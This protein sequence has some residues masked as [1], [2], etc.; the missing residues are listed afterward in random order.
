MAQERLYNLLPRVYRREDLRKGQPLRALMAVLEN[1]YDTLEQDIRNL[2]DNWFIETCAEWCIPYIGDLLGIAGLTAGKEFPGSWRAL[3]ANTIHNRRRKGTTAVLEN[4]AREATGWSTLA[5]EFFEGLAVTQTLKHLRPQ[6]GKI[7]DIKD[8]ITLNTLDTPFDRAAHTVDLRGEPSKGAVSGLIQT[9]S[10]GKYNIPNIG[11]YLWRLR[12]YPVTGGDAFKVNEGYYTF[13]PFGLDMPLFNLPE[14]QVDDICMAEER[15]LPVRLRRSGWHFDNITI[16]LKHHP[17]IRVY[18]KKGPGA[19]VPKETGFDFMTGGSDK[20]KTGFWDTLLQNAG[21]GTDS[22]DYIEILPVNMRVVNLEEWRVPADLL[23][24][25]SVYAVIDPELGRLV[26]LHDIHPEGVKVDYAYGFSGNIGGGPYSRVLSSPG[27]YEIRQTSLEA[28]ESLLETE[29][30]ARRLIEVNGG[31][32][33]DTENPWSAGNT[34]DTGKLRFR[35][36]GSALKA[37]TEQGKQGVIRILDSGTYDS[38]GTYRSYMEKTGHTVELQGEEWLVIEAADSQNP[39]I[40]GDFELKGSDT[41]GRVDLNGLWIDGTITISGSIEVN[42][43]HCTIKPQHGTGVRTQPRPALSAQRE[44]CQEIRITLSHCIIGPVQLPSNTRQLH[45]THSIID[46]LGGYAISASRQETGVQSSILYGPPASL[47]KTTVLGYAALV[48]L[49]QADDVLFTAPVTVKDTNTGY[50]RFSNI[51]VESRTPLMYQCLDRYDREEIR[52]FFTSWHF[53]QPGY[54]QLSPRCPLEIR[55]GA[56]N[57]AEMGAFNHLFQSQ[58]EAN[59]RE[60][61]KEY[62]PIGLKPEIFYV[63]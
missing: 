43:T 46:G 37:W 42:L 20:P 10:R 22:N 53:G 30:G 49:Q 31:Q 24:D 47:E 6:K 29:P 12:S 35:T 1:E 7:L 50:V 61:L 34:G 28:R 15:N 8:V 25:G 58:R 41:R 18:I 4:V 57:G 27:S 13:N 38:P 19:A 39:C 9:G 63:S 56:G 36:L 59:L 54:G 40:I 2:Y 44:Q 32:A 55:G 16:K 11:L 51:P 45:V 5:V 60:V 17:V 62:F 3:V 33:G 21:P 52:S 23:L 48:R 14:T 26:F